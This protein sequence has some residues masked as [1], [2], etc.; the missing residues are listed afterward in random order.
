MQTYV[1]VDHHCVRNIVD[2]LKI[3]YDR[4][5]PMGDAMKSKPDIV[6]KILLVKLRK[7]MQLL[8]HPDKTLFTRDTES[9]LLNSTFAECE[10][11]QSYSLYNWIRLILLQSNEITSQIKCNHINC[12]ENRATSLYNSYITYKCIS[13]KLNVTL[14]DFRQWLICD[15]KL[16]HNVYMVNDVDPP[17]S[18]EEMFVI[19]DED[20][21]IMLR[22]IYRMISLCITNTARGTFVMNRYFAYPNMKY[23]C[24]SLN[25]SKF[26]T[27][28]NQEVS[29]NF[30]GSIGDNLLKR[31]IIR[32][33]FELKC[34]NS[35]L[36]IGN[37]QIQRTK[38]F[39]T[40]KRKR[41]K[42]NIV[43]IT[44]PQTCTKLTI[45]E[46]NMVK[47]YLLSRSKLK[48]KKRE[49]LVAIIQ[50]YPVSKSI[51]NIE[52]SGAS[53]MPIDIYEASL[54][55]KRYIDIRPKKILKSTA[56]AYIGNI[57]RLIT[58][59]Q[60]TMIELNNTYKKNKSGLF[61]YGNDKEKKESKYI[62]NMSGISVYLESR[63]VMNYKIHCIV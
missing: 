33:E 25:I 10:H 32:Y 49:K 31:M 27:Y 9:K 40:K 47:D 17:E 56:N 3:A 35:E 21:L 20:L 57:K 28:W 14:R 45:P 8:Y 48:Q 16:P 19:C 43:N 24:Q 6:E 39:F 23:N 34:H 2:N 50:K 15:K 22:R 63:N 41:Q 5:D 61:F 30:Q 11:Y 29:M 52:I 54:I 7:K 4:I 55:L 60:F 26:E 59:Q 46:I 1:P 62:R 53:N 13:D 58:T 44:C 18:F 37:E 36:K 38:I 12:Q 51:P 42:T